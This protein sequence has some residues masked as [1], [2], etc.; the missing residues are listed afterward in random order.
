MMLAQLSEACFEGVIPSLVATVGADGLPNIAYLSQ[1][2]RID[3]GLVGIS[4]QFFGKTATNLQANPRAALLLVDGLTGEQ[5]ELAA[6]FTETRNSGSMFDRF[7]AQLDAEFAAFGLDE[8]M[9][10][11]AVDLFRVN[12]VNAVPGNP[13]LSVDPRRPPTIAAIA[14]V[15]ERIALETETEQI[16]DATLDGVCGALGCDAAMVFAADAGDGA[17]AT[18]GSRGYDSSGVGAEVGLQ[19]GL[20]R[21][22]AATGLALRLNDL[23]RSKRM[24]GAVRATATPESEHAIALPSLPDAQSQLAVPLLWHGV[25]QGVLFAESRARLAFDDVA[26]RAATII[27]LQAGAALSMAD[28]GDEGEPPGVPASTGAAAHRTTG[29]RVV[30]T[31]HSHDDSVFLNGDYVTRGVAGRLLR[32]MMLEFQQTGRTEFTNMQL[33]RMRDLKLPDFKDNL[34]T[35]LLMLRR[36]LDERGMPVRLTRTGRGKIRLDAPADIQ[37]DERN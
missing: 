3:D 19:P 21:I 34:E 1:V 14:Q 9:R 16:L 35:R 32:L 22:A 28:R 37:I 36:R 20:I 2:I 11:R 30:L 31:H 8:V 12:G 18:V 7:K 15:A 23:S 10:L 6:V 24:A 27:A 5:F 33:R 25:L 29:T 4:N 13:P 17:L 26:V